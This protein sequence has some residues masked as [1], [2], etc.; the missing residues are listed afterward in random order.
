[1]EYLFTIFHRLNSGSVKLN[2]QEIRNCIFSGRF[3]EFL[4]GL[5]HDQTWIQIKGSRYA[6]NDR[7]RGQEL[8]LRFLAF[9]EKYD[10]YSG[11][12]ARF[13]NTYMKE[14]RDP[15]D[16][17]IDSKQSIFRRTNKLVNDAV[18]D[19][20]LDRRRS[21]SVLEAVLVGVSKNLD[22]L[23]TKSVTEIRRMFINLLNSDEFSEDRLREGLSSPVR[24]KERMNAAVRVFSGN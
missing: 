19:I 4:K 14:H 13:L 10:S 11:G 24:V 1:M 6:T 15:K 21:I 18:F 2:N 7:Y 17:F 9:N 20:G 8:I 3:N 5:D 16:H 23:E 22:Q 12:L